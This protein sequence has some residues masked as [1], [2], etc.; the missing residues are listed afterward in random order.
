MYTLRFQVHCGFSL[1]YK[2]CELARWVREA[3]DQSA[4]KER[5]ARYMPFLC[6]PFLSIWYQL[7]L[8]HEKTILRLSRIFKQS[9]I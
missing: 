2:R 6:L 9:L 1:E 3:M 7:S 5:R 8:L 4:E